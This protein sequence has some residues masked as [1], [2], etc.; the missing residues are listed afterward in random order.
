[1]AARRGIAP[2]V[3]DPMRVAPDI[4]ERCHR[5]IDGPLKRRL[6]VLV[7]RWH[8][9]RMGL[10]Q[11]GNGFQFGP[12][13]HVPSGSRLGHYGYIGRGFRAQSPISVGD[14]CLIST[15]VCIVGNDH[16]IDDPDTPTRLAFRW[17]HAITVFEADVWV[18]H[19]AIIR[20]GVRLGRGSVIGAGS[21]VTRDVPPYAVVAGNPARLIKERFPD[22]AQRRHHDLAVYGRTFESQ[23]PEISRSCA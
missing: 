5:E 8:S 10:A 2:V 14:L 21:I 16:G 1:M 22:P 9:R 20:A 12:D 6:R 4:L 11:V 23:F 19:G 15:M 17:A 13:I 7:N 3:P 18:G